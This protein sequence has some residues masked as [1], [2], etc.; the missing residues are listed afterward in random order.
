MGPAPGMGLPLVDDAV[1]GVRVSVFLA[2][3]WGKQIAEK[4][5]KNLVLADLISR[6]AYWADRVPVD[7]ENRMCAY[8]HFQA[9]MFS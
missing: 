9:C 3:L 6:T 7:E 5:N 2:E 8:Y 4:F 1:D